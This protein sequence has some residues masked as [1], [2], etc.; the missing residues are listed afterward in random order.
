MTTD[1][2]PEDLTAEGKNSFLADKLIQVSA[3][4]HDAT[5]RPLTRDQ[6]NEITAHARKLTALAEVALDEVAVSCS[7]SAEELAELAADLQHEASRPPY[8]HRL[9]GIVTIARRLSHTASAMLGG[10]VKHIT[11]R[12]PVASLPLP[13]FLTETTADLAHFTAR[14]LTEANLRRIARLAEYLAAAV[15]NKIE[16]PRF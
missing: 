5:L 10:N 4:L 1:H 2:T 7:V 6:L 16:N 8:V 15:E 12:M 13:E 11:H 3:D 9:V 14:P